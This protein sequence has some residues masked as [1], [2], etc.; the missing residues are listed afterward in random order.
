M[1]VGFTPWVSSATLMNRKLGDGNVVY[2]P[3]WYHGIN[4]DTFEVIYNDYPTLESEFH[5]LS[6]KMLYFDIPFIMEEQGFGANNI[7]DGDS[8]DVW[9]K[10]ALVIHKTSNLIQGW[11]YYCYISYDGVPQG[12][13]WQSILRN[14]LT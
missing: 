10:N 9:L 7:T 12:G 13:G 14:Y 6:D 1:L 4:A 11:L 3:H 8:R 5:S 2:C